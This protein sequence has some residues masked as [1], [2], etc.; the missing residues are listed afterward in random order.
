MT[1]QSSVAQHT[2]LNYL[3]KCMLQ[4]QQRLNG[5]TARLPAWV[6]VS[7]QDSRNMF[8]LRHTHMHD[9]RPCRSTR[10]SRQRRNLKEAH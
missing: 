5:S 2:L 4:R 7:N 6:D 10:A 3:L 1:L 9:M 8:Y